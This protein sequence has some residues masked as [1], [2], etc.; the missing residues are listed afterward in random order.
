MDR[1][2]EVSDAVQRESSSQPT[3]SGQIESLLRA[4]KHEQNINSM[5]AMQTYY[6]KRNNKQTTNQSK[7]AR[8]IIHRLHFRRKHNS[9]NRRKFF[10]V[11]LCYRT[12]CYK[13]I[14]IISQELKDNK[15]IE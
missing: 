7:Q 9:R 6:N 4:V 2:L 15:T 11:T 5:A 3:A 1:K 14:N 10:A 13:R 12:V 8:S